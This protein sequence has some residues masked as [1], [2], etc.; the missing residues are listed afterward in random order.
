MAWNAIDHWLRRKWI[1]RIRVSGSVKLQIEDVEFQMFSKWDDG[2]VDAIY[3]KNKE[4]SELNE[5]RL[6]KELAKKSQHILDIGANTGL[7]SIVSQLSNSQVNI[8]AF[9]PYP[10]NTQRL[11]KNIALNKLTSQINI[12]V[13]AV[14]NTN[15]PVAFA[16]PENDQICDVLSADTE[17]TQQFYRKWI[18]YKNIEVPQITLDDFVQQQ[19]ISHVDLIKIDVE[20]YETNVFKGALKVLEKHNPLI[21]VEIFVTP[22]KITFFEE[23]IKPLGYHCYMMLKEGIIRVESLIGNP[24]CRNFLFARKK[25]D[26]V[27]LSFRD[28]P[29]LVQQI[30]PS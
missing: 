13:K 19:Q 21:L 26:E 5:I 1:D 20:N 18:N 15:E 12:V 29:A 6:F 11:Q 24:D 23:Y 28:L 3:L 17:F 4:Y 7:Y 16:V 14:G 8:H 27:Y 9:E 2:I 22:E 10:V 25:S 30:M